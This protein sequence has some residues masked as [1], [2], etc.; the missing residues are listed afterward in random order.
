MGAEG[1]GNDDAPITLPVGIQECAFLAHSI[2][3]WI[4]RVRPIFEKP[5]EREIV[6]H[7]N[8]TGACPCEACVDWGSQQI[9]IM[10]INSDPAAY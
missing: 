3:I 5:G 1:D 7:R 2:R 8:R 10:L 6:T 4:R 9:S